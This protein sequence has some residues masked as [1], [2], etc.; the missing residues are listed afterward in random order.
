[1]NESC[2]FKAISR[3]D[4]RVLILGTLPGKVSLE[5]GE[6]YAQPRNAFWR[7]M[8]ELI[9][10]SPELCYEHRK[11]Q[12][13]ERGIALWD[14]LASGCRAGSLD[15]EIQ[16]STV[17]SNDFRTFFEMH[18]NI[19]LICFNGAKAAKIYE[20]KVLPGLLVCLRQIPRQ[21]LPSTSPAHAAMRFE[22]KLSRWRIV[23]REGGIS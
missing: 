20:S 4:A 18:K 22:Q 10:C 14:V 11:R 2:G 15:S 7:I 19:E 13:I 1:M 9:G 21:I 8:A 3:S 17:V 12:L 6:Y 16:M 5:T 23:L